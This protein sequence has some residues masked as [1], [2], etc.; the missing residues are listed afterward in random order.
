MHSMYENTKTTQGLYDTANHLWWRDATFKPPSTTQCYW[1]RGNGWVFA[2]LTRILDVIPANE[3]HRSEYV[4]DFT[5]MAG[6]LKAIQRSDGFWNQ[7]LT[8]PNQDGGPELTGTALFAYGMAWGLRTGVLDSSYGPIVTKAWCAMASAV[9]SNGFL[10]YVQ[11]SGSAPAAGVTFD[12]VPDFQDFGLGSFLL[13]GSEVYKL[14]S[15]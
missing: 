10:G 6:A 12:S 8:N 13:G 7:S 1:S 14:A 9:H 15:P 3:S 2:A 4:S 5:A 11:G